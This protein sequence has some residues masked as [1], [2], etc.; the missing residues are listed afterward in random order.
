MI[1]GANAQASASQN[2]Q[3]ED[4]VVSVATNRI[5]IAGA[6]QGVEFEVKNMLGVVVYQGKITRDGN[7]SFEIDLKSGFYIV[8]IGDTLKRI[9]VK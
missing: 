3:E 5:F 8:R 4:I 1:F 9:V 6:R 7:D 2:T